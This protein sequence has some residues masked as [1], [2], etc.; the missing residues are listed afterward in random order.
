MSTNSITW[1]GMDAH[2]NSI[3]VAVLLPEQTDPVEWTE[4]TT[5][6]A[7]RRL[8]RRLQ[9]QAPGEVADATRP[10]RRRRRRS[11]ARSTGGACSGSLRWSGLKVGRAPLFVWNQA[12]SRSSPKHQD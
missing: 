12:N 7:V 1:V 9:R 6:E 5:S 3:K 2:K 10:G 8:A 11:A 4:D